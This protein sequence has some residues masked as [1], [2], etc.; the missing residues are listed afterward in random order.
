MWPAFWFVTAALLSVMGL[1]LGLDVDELVTGLGRSRARSGGWYSVRRFVQVAMVLAVTAIWIAVAYVA[2]GRV[3]E[4]RRRYLAP[5][6]LISGLAVFAAVRF[7]SLH[8]IDT[9]LYRRSIAT[10]RVAAVVELGLIALLIVTTCWH[11]GVATA[12]RVPDVKS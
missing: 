6:L 12:G 7:V 1:G 4:R 8:S 5:T 2:I 3:M 9:V 11:P 10:V